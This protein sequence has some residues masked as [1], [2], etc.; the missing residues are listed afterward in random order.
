M[1]A[2]NYRLLEK[3]LCAAEDVYYNQDA[4]GQR[5]QEIRKELRDLITKVVAERIRA[6]DAEQQRQSQ[7]PET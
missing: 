4:F 1:N 3:Q 6:E 2:Q 7:A 5:A